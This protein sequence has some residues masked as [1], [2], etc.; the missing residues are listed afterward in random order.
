VFIAIEDKEL[1]L[2]QFDELM[3]YATSGDS[4]DFPF[5]LDSDPK[6]G[7]IVRVGCIVFEESDMAKMWKDALKDGWG[8]IILYEAEGKSWKDLYSIELARLI[9]GCDWVRERV[10]DW[11]SV[12]VSF[13]LDSLKILNAF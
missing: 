3:N 8:P 10:E 13:P 12:A 6:G 2:R 5:G 7:G 1:A 4:L 11:S 9:V